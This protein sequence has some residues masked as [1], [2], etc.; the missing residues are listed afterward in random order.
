M[1]PVA[2]KKQLISNINK[3][4][5]LKRSVFNSCLEMYPKDEWENLMLKINK[6]NLF[7]LQQIVVNI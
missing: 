5:V 6:L 2:L 3:G 1:L 4:F 7:Q